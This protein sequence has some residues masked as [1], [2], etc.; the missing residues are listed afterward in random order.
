MDFNRA[1]V[2]YR[3]TYATLTIKSNKATEM[4]MVFNYRPQRSW[5]KVIFSEACVKNSVHR[6]G[7]HGKGAYMVG[8]VCGRG[9]AWQGGMCSRGACMTGGMHGRGCAWQGVHGGSVHCRGHAWQRGA[10]W[11]VCMVGGMRGGRHAWHTVNEQAVRILLECILVML[12]TNDIVLKKIIVSVGWLRASC[13]DPRFA[14]CCED[15]RFVTCCDDP[16]FATCN[17]ASDPSTV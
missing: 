12:V 10:W 3:H 5:D 4:L 15:P 6:G 2:D 1:V 13:E 17:S 14:T 7:M 9:C 11:G 8:G 16:R